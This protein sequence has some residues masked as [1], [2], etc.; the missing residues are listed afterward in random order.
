M[1]YQTLVNDMRIPCQFWCF[2]LSFVKYS[3]I[4]LENY[5]QQKEPG[6]NNLN[7]FSN[8]AQVY[9]FP[10]KSQEINKFSLRL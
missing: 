7:I 3:Y 2:A 1:S 6:H 9:H 4:D 10:T 5:S 8:L